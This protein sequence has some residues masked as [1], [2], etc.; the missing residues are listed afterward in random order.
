MLLAYQVFHYNLP[1]C[2]DRLNFEGQLLS[3]GDKTVTFEQPRFPIQTALN[4][5]YKSLKS[6]CGWPYVYTMVVREQPVPG[7][8]QV[9]P[10]NLK[11]LR[12][13]FDIHSQILFSISVEV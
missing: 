3:E 5:I 13:A 4:S 7:I 8:K 6:H 12:F 9:S 10:L 11:C 2:L 1:L